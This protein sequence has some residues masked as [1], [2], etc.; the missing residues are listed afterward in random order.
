ML[1]C[2]ACGSADLYEVLGG[3][4]GTV[5][6]CKKCGYTGSF[7]IESDEE[8]PPP[9][10]QDPEEGENRFALPLWIK[11]AAALLLFYLFLMLLMNF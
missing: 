4:A 5:Y 8:L 11:I 10:T 2:P 3:Y 9:E 6:R 7:V 1:R